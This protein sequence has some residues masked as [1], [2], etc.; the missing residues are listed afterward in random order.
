[1]P[2]GETT[3]VEPVATRDHTERMLAVFGVPVQRYGPQG[4]RAWRL[5]AQGEQGSRFPGDALVRGVLGRRR[6]AGP[7]SE[8]AVRGVGA[9]ATRTGYLSVLARMGA[10]IHREPLRG[11]GERR[12]RI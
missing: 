11:E 9:N 3:V 7:G 12:S 10:D 4:C 6:D 8:L 2:T 5:D 1:M